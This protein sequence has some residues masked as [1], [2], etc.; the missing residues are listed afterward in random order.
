M[1][2]CVAGVC[3]CSW[4]VCVCSWCV[5]V[6]DVCVCVAVVCS[7]YSTLLVVCSE[8]QMQQYVVRPMCHA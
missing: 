3:V 4:C 7:D 1:Y 6:A 5:C 2:V 8:K